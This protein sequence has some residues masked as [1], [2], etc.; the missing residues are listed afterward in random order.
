MKADIQASDALRAMLSG[1]A[2]QPPKWIGVNLSVTADQ[3][4]RWRQ[5]FPDVPSIVAEL[6]VFDDWL[7]ENGVADGKLM[8]RA[9]R[10]LANA[11]AKHAAQKR[12]PLDEIYPPEIYGNL[13]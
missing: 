11:D 8:H 12:N 6:Q 4:D 7:T 1:E 10:W 2:Q 5:S 9:S 3:F 13:Q